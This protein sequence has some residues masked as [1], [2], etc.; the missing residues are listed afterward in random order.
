[1]PNPE[2]R[3][4]DVLLF[5]GK[6]L[7]SWAIRRLDGTD[8]NHAAVALDDAELGEATAVGLVTNPIGAVVAKNDYTLIRRLPAD[9]LSM[10]PVVDTAREYLSSGA[11]Y[12]F[13]QILLLAILTLTRRL[14]FKDQLIRRMV[15][16]ILDRAALLLNSFIDAGT[17]LMICSEFVFR[18]YDEAGDDRYRLAGWER[19][20]R[21]MPTDEGLLLDWA[22]A[23]PLPR[24]PVRA[25][26]SEVEEPLELAVR[27]EGELEHLI[28][29]FARADSPTDREIAALDQLGAPK[30]PP[31]ETTD[32][33]LLFATIRFRDAMVRRAGQT[34]GDVPDA[35]GVADPWELLEETMADFVTP[36]DLLHSASLVTVGELL[37]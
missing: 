6:G 9:D 21:D 10:A 35:R 12:A 27:M 28:A 36:G 34:A 11:P 2:I 16:G 8:V 17:D 1:M 23:Q 30:A 20:V 29:D 18:C 31:E 7:V 5:H 13:Q 37:P 26:T 33:Q 4:G 22:K 14:S 32:E 25:A 3:A 19:A 24:A 15:R